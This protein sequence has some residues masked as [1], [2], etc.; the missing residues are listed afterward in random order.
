MKTVRAIDYK[1]RPLFIK[2][3]NYFWQ[4]S[5]PI[6]SKIKLD[7][8]LLIRAARKRTGLANF[9]SDFWEEPL[10]VLLQSV[11]EEARL[12]PFG[13]FITQ[14][15]LINLLV[16]RLIAE[17]WFKKHPEILEQSL[18]PVYLI[19][20]LQ[21]TGTTKLQRLLAADPDTRPLLSW[22]A[23]NPAPLETNFRKGDKRIRA[24]KRAE[25]ALRFM[26]PGFF[27]IHPVE[28]LSPEEDILLLDV[29]FMSTTAEATMQVP[30][31]AA[32]LEQNDQSTAYTYA[33]KLLKL[34]QW[35]RPGKRWV[36]KSPH[37]LEFFETI[38]KV[39]DQLHII[40]THRDVSEC[41][42]SFLSMVA[43]GR[44]I[45]SDDVRLEELTHHWL[46]KIQY[47]LQKG[48]EFRVQENHKRVFTDIFYSEFI[49]HPLA[50]IER[51]YQHIGPISQDLRNLFK[52]HEANNR[53]AKFGGHHYSME[54]FNLNQKTIDQ[55]TRNY[56]LFLDTINSSKTK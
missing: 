42:P 31:Y 55:Y 2:G 29:S 24:A 35:Q 37:H 9:G 54:D 15:R 22:E 30:T 36:L 21:R 19:A 26:A 46:R 5:Y 13:R 51:I 10:D 47:M 52:S 33:K 3:L 4:R 12:H 8:D 25:K 53:P 50:E 16:V 40:W 20:G 17:W 28:H 48:M 45:F 34:L 39:Y 43:H 23:L 38:K 49:S 11:N 56:Q 1:R 32:W 41:L 44:A 27:A 14:Q 6:G 7:K 18:Y